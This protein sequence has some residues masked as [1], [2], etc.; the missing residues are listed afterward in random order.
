MKRMGD[1]GKI[2]WIAAAIASFGFTV[3]TEVA[4]QLGFDV[5]KLSSWRSLANDDLGLILVNYGVPA[6]L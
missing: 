1:D 2:Y 5:N 6:P 3:N 4:Q